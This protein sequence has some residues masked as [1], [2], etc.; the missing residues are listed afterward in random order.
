M[1][2]R[3]LP[4]ALVVLAL[5]SSLNAQAPAAPKT[6]EIQL[7]DIERRL[8]FLDWY[9][10]DLNARTPVLT[11]LLA[12]DTGD[13]TTFVMMTSNLPLFA[14]CTKLEPYLEGYR[15]TIAIMNVLAVQLGGLRGA[16]GHGETYAKATS[17]T[18]PFS[19]TRSLVPGQWTS[20][21]VVISLAV[22]K[23]VRFIQLRDV[24]ATT[25]GGV[26]QP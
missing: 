22:A 7:A 3:P 20:I 4:I 21:D 9:S 17:Q 24:V 19:T 15:V 1:S 10:E 18:I 26:L 2:Y 12:C 5:S 23:D 16:L 8:N 6:L 13:F 14:K 11:P 25:V